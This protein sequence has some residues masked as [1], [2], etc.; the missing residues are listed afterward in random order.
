MTA[1]EAGTAAAWGLYVCWGRFPGLPQWSVLARR[2]VLEE[3]SGEGERPVADV[4]TPL[5]HERE[6]RRTREIR[7]EAGMTTSQG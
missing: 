3:P 4:D 6:Y 2:M 7:W 1:Y 5:Q